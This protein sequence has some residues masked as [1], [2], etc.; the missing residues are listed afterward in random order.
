[1][2][3]GSAGTFLVSLFHIRLGLNQLLN[4]PQF[5]Q[6]CRSSQHLSSQWACL[7]CCIVFAA[8]S[9]GSLQIKCLCS[10]KKNNKLFLNS[11]LPYFSPSINCKNLHIWLMLLHPDLK[12][13]CFS[14]TTPSKTDSDLLTTIFA[15]F[16]FLFPLPPVLTINFHLH[17]Y[18][19]QQS[20]LLPGLRQGLPSARHLWVSHSHNCL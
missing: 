2:H 6:H 17:N 5:L 14:L 10:I 1:M 3:D 16:C 11:I 13:R 7:N 18:F 20:H 15:G 8:F 12:P 19:A 4:F 9:N